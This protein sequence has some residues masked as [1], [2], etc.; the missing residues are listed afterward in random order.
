MKL[1]NQLVNKELSIKLDKL[2][3][4]EESLYWHKIPNK[5]CRNGAVASI[6]EYPEKSK[7]F[8]YYR[9]YTV[10]ELGEM[11][12]KVETSEKLEYDSYLFYIPIW[13]GGKKKKW[14]TGGSLGLFIEDKTEANARAKIKIYLVKHKL[15]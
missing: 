12:K 1:E 15:I 10:A 2:G 8:D 13:Y 6:V 9:A 7:W 4:K 3:V 11:L 5:R 14:C